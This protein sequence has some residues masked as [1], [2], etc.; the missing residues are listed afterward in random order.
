MYLFSNRWVTVVLIFPDSINIGKSDSDPFL[1][2]KKIGEN[3][4][5]NN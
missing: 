1:L 3:F 5:F 2:E 4:N